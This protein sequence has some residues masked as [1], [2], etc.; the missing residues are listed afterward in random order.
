MRYLIN[1]KPDPPVI[2]DTYTLT[3]NCQVDQMS[4]NEKGEVNTSRQLSFLI[5]E[6]FQLCSFCFSGNREPDDDS[7]GT[8]S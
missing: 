7:S 2:H 1:S 5:R 3:E 6:S 4:D 8:R